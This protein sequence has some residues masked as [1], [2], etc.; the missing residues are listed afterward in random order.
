MNPRLL[1]IVLIISVK[2]NSVRPINII[3]TANLSG[4]FQKD[5]ERHGYHLLPYLTVKNWSK[6]K[7]IK[8]ILTKSKTPI[9]FI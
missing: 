3:L 6:P 4:I 7:R 2:K 8:A 1:S 9:K 5:I